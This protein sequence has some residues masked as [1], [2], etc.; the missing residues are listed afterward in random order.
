MCQKATLMYLLQY[1]CSQRRSGPGGHFPTCQATP[2]AFRL[3]EMKCA[4]VGPCW[5]S[6]GE[7]AWADEALELDCDESKP[8]NQIFGRIP[9]HGLLRLLLLFM[10][11]SIVLIAGGS[12]REIRAEPQ[13]ARIVGLGAT[14]CLQFNEDI[15]LNLSVQRDYLAW[16][17]CYMSGILVVGRLVSTRVSILIP[18]P[19]T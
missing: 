3:K 13:T 6:E 14:T 9:D 19:L 16:G 2:P 4:S 7:M 10:A 12:R 18:Q 15:R 5:Y 11:S 17:Q 1:A 8:I